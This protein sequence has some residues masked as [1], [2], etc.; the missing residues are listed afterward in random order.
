ML[1]TRYVK[2]RVLNLEMG[3]APEVGYCTWKWALRLKT[4]IAPG[5]GFKPA[6]NDMIVQPRLFTWIV[7][8]A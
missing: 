2:I 3:I 6:S 7:G 4:G 1:A 8:L 5:N